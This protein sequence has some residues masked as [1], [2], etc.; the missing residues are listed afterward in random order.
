MHSK[1]ELAAPA[2][3][4]RGGLMDLWNK[5]WVAL[6]QLTERVD[7]LHGSSLVEVTAFRNGTARAQHI[8][9]MGFP[10]EVT[11]HLSKFENGRRMITA[12]VDAKLYATKKGAMWIIGT[13][14]HKGW[15]VEVA[16]TAAREI[17]TQLES[18]AAESR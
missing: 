15:L 16:H 10:I 14:E 7:D 1:Y 13:I 2:Q 3:V 12:I 8:E 9:D 17:Y 5:F 11:I 4:A 6:D 18:Q